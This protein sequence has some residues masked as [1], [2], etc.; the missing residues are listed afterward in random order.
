VALPDFFVIGA[1]KA[2]TTA[3]HAALANHPQL[4]LSK[5][6]EPK[7][8]LDDGA[9]PPRHSG[10][11][12]AHSDREWVWR[13]PDYEALFAGAPP[14]CLR[15][16][17]TPFYLSD[18]EAQRRIHDEIPEAKLIA[19]LRDPV[20]RAYSNWTHLWSDGLEPVSD[21]ERACDL[22]AERAA[23]GWAPFWRYTGLGMYGRHLQHLF[24]H[25]PPEQVFVLRY[26]DLVD[27]P[28]TTLNR[29]CDFLGVASDVVTDVPSRNVSTYVAPSRYARVLQ[30]V[31][32]GGAAIGRFFP[33]KLWRQAS[34]PLLWALQ[35]QGAN[36]PE[37]LVDQRRR[38]VARFAD[39]IR[40]LEQITGVSYSDWLTDRV[41]G[42]YSVRKA[43]CT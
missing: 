1:P 7:F 4:H 9:R 28:N 35:R 11:G 22:E 3:V 42:T 14:G 40:L 17:S 41:G 39:D 23:A 21:F 36:R 10:P 25:F 2:G 19:I 27:E 32:R 31:V 33:P 20:D 34:V 29:I 8:Y 37:L 24:T 26:R 15:G 16:E 12:D 13:R 6:K 30:E 18:Y 38:M 43:A 5:V